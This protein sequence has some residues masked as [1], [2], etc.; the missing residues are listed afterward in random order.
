M[1]NTQKATTA[2]RAWMLAAC[3]L[4]V[5]GAAPARAT[6]AQDSVP[7]NWLYVTV[8]RGDTRGALLLCDP[9]QGHPRAVRACEELQAADGDI[10]RIPDKDAYCAMLYAPV[11]ASARGEWGGRRVT[12]TETFANSC[13][14][15][16]KTGAVFALS[17]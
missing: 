15:A 4:L 6:A 8:S 1:T 13:V 7:G 12:Y 16:A 17:D 3:A 2:V 11:T 9:P 14:M 10:G 5:A